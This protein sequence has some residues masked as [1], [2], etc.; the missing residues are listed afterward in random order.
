MLARF[1]LVRASFIPPK[2]LRELRLVSRYRRKLSAICAS[3]AKVGLDTHS[4][5]EALRHA[6]RE[7]PD[8]IMI[9]EIRD[10]AAMQHAMAYAKTGHLCVST[11]HANNANNANQA[12][13]R[14]LNFFPETVH[15]QVPMDLSLN[16]KRM[17]GQ[18]LIQGTATRAAAGRGDTLSQRPSA[19][20]RPRKSLLQVWAA[21]SMRMRSLSC[22]VRMSVPAMA[23]V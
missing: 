22:D 14:V 19:V 20:A 21:V 1:G 8:V 10:R 7:A 18:R 4:F 11:L 17:V 15:K 12:I 23:K 5:D 3:Q 13:Q 6:M 9:G 16:L 2:D